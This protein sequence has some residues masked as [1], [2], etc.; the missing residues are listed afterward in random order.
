MG[1]FRMAMGFLI[2]VNQLM[3][4]WDFSYWFSERGF[5]PLETNRQYLGD[6]P[7]LTLLP[8]VTDDRIMALFYIAVTIAAL[9]SCIG[10]WT[11]VSTIVLALGIITLHHRNAV[12][13]HGGDLVIRMGAIY[14]ALAPSG[15]ACS[16]DRLIGLWKGKAPPIPA[17]V[18][19]WPQRLVQFQVALV[20]FTTVWH[21]WF[22]TYWREGWAT[23]YPLHLNE[24][25]RFPLPDFM[26]EGLFVRFA[27]YGTLIV[28]LALATLVFFKPW[29]KWAL[30]GGVAL[31]LFIEYSMNIPLFAFLMITT[32]LSFFEGEEISTWAKRVGSRLKR[33]ALTVLVPRGTVLRPGPGLALGA[34]DSFGLVTYSQGDDEGWT[35]V[36]ANGESKPPFHASGL[37]SPGAWPILWIPG[38]W[39]GLLNRALRRLEVP[40]QEGEGRE[41][42]QGAA[43]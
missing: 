35:A 32:Y 13:L 34:V 29:R 1:L 31:H 38:V 37:R 8:G 42:G 2:F 19:L 23:W 21:K 18:S 36:G 11:R 14:M 30:L 10:L 28:E 24:F 16:V 4:G 27:T 39:K 3:L 9:T 26:R 6:F 40:A 20:Y 33:L 25:E 22:G 43:K 17:E 12:V 7:R 5:V 15:A 41:R